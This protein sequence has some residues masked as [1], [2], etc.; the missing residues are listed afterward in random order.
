MTVNS[1]GNVNM[2]LYIDTTVLNTA[3]VYIKN[4]KLL[5]LWILILITMN[6][7]MNPQ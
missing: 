7:K 2:Q 5:Q 6:F 1:F 4:I 3:A